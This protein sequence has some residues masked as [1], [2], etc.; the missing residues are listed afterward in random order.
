MKKKKEFLLHPKYILSDFIRL[1]GGLKY[2]I[3]CYPK[4]HYEE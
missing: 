2:R 1:N 3:F 4:V